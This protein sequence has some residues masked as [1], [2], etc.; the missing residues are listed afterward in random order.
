M[1]AVLVATVNAEKKLYYVIDSDSKNRDGVLVDEKGGKVVNF[2]KTA[3][4][5]NGLKPIKSSNFHKYLWDNDFD[6]SDA[7]EDRWERIFINKTQKVS[8]NLLSGIPI[9]TD[10]LKSKIKSKSVDRR[11]FEFKSLLQTQNVSIV[12]LNTQKTIKIEK[13]DTK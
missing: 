1:K 9:V 10:V 6:G 4:K 8:E 7:D 5:L 13:L 2:W 3:A 12:R 11:V